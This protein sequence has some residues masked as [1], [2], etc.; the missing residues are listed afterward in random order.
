MNPDSPIHNPADEALEARIVSWVLGEASAFEAAEL[1]RL[2]EERPELLVFRR[3]MRDLHGLLTDSEA[4]QPDDGWK[5]PEEKRKVLDEIFG[6]SQDGP[7]NAIH[8]AQKEKRI[9]HS[10]RRALLAIAACVVLTLVVLS[11]VP[12]TYQAETVIEVKPLMGTQTATPQIFGTEFERIKSRK[13]LEAVATNLELPS[14]WGVDQETAVRRLRDAVSTKAIRGTDLVAIRAREKDPALAKDIANEVTKEYKNYRASIE[15]EHAERQL[16]ELNKAVRDQEDKVEERRKV[17]ATIVRTKGIIYKGTDS[18]YG[19]AGVD[20]DLGAKNALQ[21]YHQLEQEKMQLEGQINSLLKYDKDQL[22]VYA[23]GLDLPDNTIRSILPEYQAATRELE[24]LKI[25]GLGDD[26][27]SVT[28]AKDQIERQKRQL[29]EGVVNLRATLKAQLDLASDRLKSVEVMKDETREEAIKR[30]LDAQDYVDA[31]REFESDQQLLQQMKLKQMG[32]TIAAKIPNESVVVHD[33]AA[34]AEPLNPLRAAVAK[35]SG[36]F[37][38]EEPATLAKNSVAAPQAAQPEDSLAYGRNRQLEIAKDLQ[39]KRAS[40]ATLSDPFASP[41]DVGGMLSANEP[42]APTAS[43]SSIVTG[44]S[45]GANGGFASPENPVSESSTLTASS[46]FDLAARRSTRAESLSQVDKSWETSLPEYKL[47]A[48]ATPG[49]PAPALGAEL[50]STASNKGQSI[51][52]GSSFQFSTEYQPP[53]LPEIASAPPEDKS[54]AV[55]DGVKGLKEEEAELIAGG[56]VLDAQSEALAKSK[57][58]ATPA[59]APVIVEEIAAAED[60]YSTFSLNISDASFQIAQAALAKGERPDPAGIKVEQFYNAVD[61]GDPAPALGEPVAA[62]IEQS[63]HPVMPG[64]SLVRVALKTAAAGRGASQPLRL[65]LLVDQSG[66]M[67]REDRRAAMDKALKGLSALLT[68]KD[69]INVIGFSRKPRLI[70]DQLQGD[71]AGQLAEL[72]HQSASE[73]G[74]NLDEAIQLADQMSAR[75]LTPGAQNR[76]VLFTDGAANLGNADPVKLAE[77]VKALRQKGIAFDIAGI[78]ADDLN[79]DLLAELA[80]NGNGRYYVV[81]K[82]G[83]DENDFAKQLAG[84]FRPAAENVKVQV[85]FNPERVARYKLIGFE[86]DRLK[87]E[88]FRNDAV[89]AAELAAEE[90]GVAIYQIETLPEG[91]GEIGEVSVRF[92]DTAANDMVERTWTMRHDPNTPAFDRATPSMQ[93]ATL[94]ML[95]A[96]KLKGG[97]LADAINFQQLAEPR[98]NVKRFYGQSGRIGQVLQMLNA[99]R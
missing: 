1:E 34:T 17:L 24:G 79:D 31:K 62:T 47:E 15:A 64:R 70:A 58:A 83:D 45:S 95:A 67:V 16:T 63:A 41:A 60:P 57:P 9:R 25:K 37:A 33:E 85:R 27:P 39:S 10:G 59:P 50:P 7:S 80:R 73:G 12:G 55:V 4:A 77:K 36:V 22:M 46:D 53:T 28:A 92:R 75:T 87:T 76:I 89:D 98:E 30:G 13:S 93:L 38:K 49:Q 81:G 88:D 3:R 19:Q 84:A 11:M 99:L 91:K 20:E 32:E 35:L 42:A 43:T 54:I 97:P 18:F 21:T 82:G 2:C 40:E 26:H 78:A 66:S 5:L 96:E 48:A 56:K 90:A 14:R 8:D 29:D 94:T 71:K 61:Y 86:K 72:I 69:S 74:T 6:S 52:G 51:G 44:G 68:E 65:T 23:S